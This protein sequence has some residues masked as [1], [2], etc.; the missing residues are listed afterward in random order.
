[1]T[2]TWIGVEVGKDGVVMAVAGEPATTPFVLAGDGP[3]AL[4]AALQR[5]RATLIVM[6]ATG[7]YERPW[8]TACATADL[9]VVVVNPRQVRVCAR[10]RAQCQDRQDRRAGARGV[11]GPRPGRW[12][13]RCLTRPGAS[14]T[15]WSRGGSSSSHV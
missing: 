4:V 8:V 6:E 2:S 10:G 3:A 14:S 1:M 13:G 5:R 12:C 15:P 7:G 11:C 9:P